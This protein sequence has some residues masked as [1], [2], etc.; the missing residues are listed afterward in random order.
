MGID[1]DEAL[2]TAHDFSFQN[3]PNL[4]TDELCGC[5][6]CLE[7]FHP[8]EIVESVDDYG[9]AT[10]LCPYCGIDSVIGESSGCPITRDF[11][12]KMHD[13]WF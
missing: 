10:A 7:I 13:R 6:Y 2:T 8:R 3:M 12:R 5:F 11:L 9:V 4:A 1:M